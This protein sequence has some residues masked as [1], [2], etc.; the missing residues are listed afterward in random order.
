MTGGFLSNDGLFYPFYP[1]TVYVKYVEREQSVGSVERPWSLVTHGGNI[2]DKARVLLLEG[3]IPPNV[4]VGFVSENNLAIDPY[5][6][7]RLE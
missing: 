4:C 2:S 7:L 1:N 5:V 6:Y 3:V